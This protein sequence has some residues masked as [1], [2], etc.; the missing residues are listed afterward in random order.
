MKRDRKAQLKELKQQKAAGGQLSNRQQLRLDHLQKRAQDTKAARTAAVP[1]Q[2]PQFQQ[3]LEPAG[4]EVMQPM[5]PMPRGGMEQPAAQAA[6]AA[7]PA[8]PQDGQTMPSGYQFDAAAGPG[9][10][11]HMYG[12]GNAGRSNQMPNPMAQGIT[13]YVR[14]MPVPGAPRTQPMPGISAFHTN[15]PGIQNAGYRPPGLM[16]LGQKAAANG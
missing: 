9:S 2:M 15:A 6:Q 14:G 5:Q 12:I 1:P 13:G 4:V 16:G 8:Q 3:Q 10:S 11:G 7:M